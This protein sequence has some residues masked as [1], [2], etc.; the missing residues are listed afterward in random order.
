MVSKTVSQLKAGFRYGRLLPELIGGASGSRA[1]IWWGV[2]IVLSDLSGLRYSKPL[3]LAWMAFPA[4]LAVPW[5]MLIELP[6]PLMASV[7]RVS[8]ALPFCV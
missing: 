5:V 8:V 7:T 2:V 3:W 1:L 4:V 6:V